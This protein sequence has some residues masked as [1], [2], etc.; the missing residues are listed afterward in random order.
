EPGA[1]R[2][3]TH[4]DHAGGGV[5]H[6]HRDEVRGHRALAALEEVAAL[7]LERE[8]AADAGADDHAEALD[9]DALGHARLLGRLRGGGDREV[10][11]AIR[12]THVLRRHGALGVELGARADGVGD[13]RLLGQERVE[14]RLGALADRADD[15]AAGDDDLGRGTHAE[16]PSFS[17]TS[18]WTRLTASPT[19]AIDFRRPSAIWIS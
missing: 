8:Q 15:A 5:G 7:L 18:S 17:R 3:E 10:G 12:A 19:V 13:A 14:E 16:T 9:V 2:A 1:V 4:R 6:H 11:V